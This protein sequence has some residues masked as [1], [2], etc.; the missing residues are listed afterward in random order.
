MLVIDVHLVSRCDIGDA[1]I[2]IACAYRSVGRF[3]EPLSYDSLL[4][5]TPVGWYLVCAILYPWPYI[6]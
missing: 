3:L 1:L 4:G 6:W 5:W 2:W